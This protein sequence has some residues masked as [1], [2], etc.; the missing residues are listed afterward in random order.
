MVGGY[1]ASMEGGG[2]HYDCT[3]VSTKATSQ[4]YKRKQGLI[5]CG[6]MGGDLMASAG[7]GEG[8]TM[9]L[10]ATEGADAAAAPEVEM[11]PL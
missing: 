8:A 5:E 1:Y 10:I 11:G 7:R 2:E 3:Q 9:E 4:D 6:G